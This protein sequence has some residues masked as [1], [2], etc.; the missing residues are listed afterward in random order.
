M[1][2]APTVLMSCRPRDLP[3]AHSVHHDDGSDRRAGDS[4]TVTLRDGH[5]YG[6]LSSDRSHATTRHKLFA[7]ALFRACTHNGCAVDICVHPTSRL[8]QENVWVCESA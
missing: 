7:H 1:I 4:G 5:S 2:D 3:R 6:Q 8:S